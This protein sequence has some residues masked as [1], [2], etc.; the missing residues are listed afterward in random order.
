M[1]TRLLI[2]AWAIAMA[3]GAP[4]AAGQ[5]GRP[6]RPHP[7][8]ACR[9]AYAGGQKLAHQGQLV[10]A[11]KLLRSCAKP[12]CGAFLEHQCTLQYGQIEAEMPTVVP[13]ATDEAGAPV[14]DVSLKVDGTALASRL[15]GRAVPINPGLH[16]FAFETRDGVVVKMKI[17]VVH[18]QRN[19][20]LRVSVKRPAAQPDRTASSPPEADRPPAGADRPPP[21]TLVVSPPA[22]PERH[23]SRWFTTGSYV[24]L[25]AGLAGVGGY[26]VLTYWGRKDNDE[27]AACSPT[28]PQS[29]VDHIDNLYLAANVSLAVGAAAL[30]GGAYL[31][32]RNHASYSVEVQ[33]TGSGAL[34][35]FGGVF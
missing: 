32:W 6:A 11:K 20:R 29:A 3:L 2:G 31:V 30:L 1:R 9:S 19:R 8:K 33:P 17:M 21:S 26:G 25:G 28:C 35:T 12:K 18:G 7:H 4:Q 5:R 10:R 13:T 23:R 24:L 14:L 16:E 15:D 34:A 27:L 22:P